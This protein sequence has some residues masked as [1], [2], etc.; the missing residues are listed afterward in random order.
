[1]SQQTGVPD[2]FYPY[3]DLVVTDVVSAAGAGVA[4]GSRPSRND[5]FDGVILPPTYS[6]SCVRRN[7]YM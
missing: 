2:N 1:M 3:Y 6:Q 5:E 7:S 4:G